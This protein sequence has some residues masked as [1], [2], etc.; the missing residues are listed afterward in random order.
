MTDEVRASGRAD[1]GPD[2]PVPLLQLTDITKRFGALT[3]NDRISLSVAPGEV[4]AMLGENGAGKS[5]LMKIVYGL[6][7]PD[8]GTIAMGGTVLDIGSPRDAMAA[9]IGMVT[10]EFSLVETMTVAENVALSGVGLGRVDLK[11]VRSQV[12]AA[13]ERVGVH[14]EPDRLVG[15]L[16]IGERQRVE[17]VKALFHDCRVLILDEPTAV[18]TPQ[19]VAALFATVRRLSA[20]GLGVLFVS[21]KLREVAEISHRVVVLRRGRLVGERRTSEVDAPALAKLMMGSTD[22]AAESPSG[23][24]TEAIAAGMPI[25][26]VA[27]P[28]DPVAATPTSGTPLLEIREVTLERDGRPVLDR[29][30]ACVHAGEILGV[31][32]ISGNGQTD[33]ME[34]LSGVTAATSGAVV[35]AGRDLTRADVATRLAVGLGRLT[36]DRRGSV[37]PQMSVE[38]NL[39]ME[40]LDT[41]ARRG[42]LD[43]KAIR[44]HAEAMI[45]RFDIRA[46][47]TD[48]MATLSGGNVQK[49]LL[50]RALVRDPRALV[51]AQPTRGL[52]IGAY[53]YVHDQLRAVR[54]AG[55]GVLVISEDLDELRALCDRIAVLF[56]GAVIGVLPTADA[57]T[58]RLGVMMTGERVPA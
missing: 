26:D 55:G 18:L 43:K 9:G 30:D 51:V 46:R 47:P 58:E 40:D 3:A 21:H 7:R 4:V 38:Y 53:H 24:A 25:E 12:L 57:S 22:S 15:S 1:A 37:I 11:G 14:L 29:V 32:G 28:G 52:D 2:A 48:A 36:E 8:E 33:L 13:M 27:G 17:I 44:T 45:E 16:S 23:S 39:V 49:V 5:T 50:A 6:N 41:Y 19:D 42:L 54:D 56:R 10:Q 34:V 31:A 35:L 20:T